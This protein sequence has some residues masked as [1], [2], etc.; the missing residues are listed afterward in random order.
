M[1]FSSVVILD[2]REIANALRDKIST[3]LSASRQ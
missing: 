2:E 3:N 1:L